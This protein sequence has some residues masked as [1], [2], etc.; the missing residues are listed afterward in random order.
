MSPI[1]GGLNIVAPSFG[2]PCS[3]CRPLAYTCKR[4]FVYTKA[5]SYIT[6]RNAAKGTPSHDHAGN[7]YRKS[8]KLG[9]PVFEICSRTDR[10]RNESEY[11]VTASFHFIYTSK[12]NVLQI[13]DATS[14]RVFIIM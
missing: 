9:L 8:V 14:V 3:A 5:E 12:E 10:P 2:P 4:D 6:Y 13:Y 1:Q 7:K 11:L